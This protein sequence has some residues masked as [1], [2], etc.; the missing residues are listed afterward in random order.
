MVSWPD[1]VVV[2]FLAYYLTGLNMVKFH[3]GLRP[4]DQPGYVELGIVRQIIAGVIWPLVGRENREFGWY[5]VC[6]VSAVIVIGLEY[7]LASKFVQSSFW[8]VMIVWTACVTPV[9]NAPLALIA[10]VLWLM[11]AKPLGLRIPSGMDR[12]GRR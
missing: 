8:R 10:M 5:A 1:V 12:L 3:R 11:V 9:V 7:W 4:H 2:L 6:F